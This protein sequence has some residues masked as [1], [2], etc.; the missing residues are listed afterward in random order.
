MKLKEIYEDR[1]HAYKELRSMHYRIAGPGCDMVSPETAA[2]VAYQLHAAAS[3]E[4][5][6]RTSKIDARPLLEE[7]MQA[8]TLLDS[9]LATVPP[10]AAAIHEA[11]RVLL[12]L[13]PEEK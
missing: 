11:M 8:V 2:A 10:S 5:F 12:S 1:M 6:H 4:W 9:A 7:A 3:H 13:F